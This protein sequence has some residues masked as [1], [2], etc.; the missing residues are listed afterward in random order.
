MCCIGR[1][2]LSSTD[3]P[4]SITGDSKSDGLVVVLPENKGYGGCLGMKLTGSA[5]RNLKITAYVHNIG[6]V[7]SLLSEKSTA[8]E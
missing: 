1:T 4:V 6:R 8:N 2:S 3:C 7:F 5:C